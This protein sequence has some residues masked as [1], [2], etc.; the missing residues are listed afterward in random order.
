M[1]ATRLALPLLALGLA[2]SDEAV[3]TTGFID[4]YLDAYCGYIMRCCDA[5]ERS[6][7]TDTACRRQR[8]PYIQAL[9]ASTAED[10]KVTLVESKA[11]DC[12]KALN[13]SDCTRAT[14]A[15]GC[16]AGVTQGQQQSGDD[17]TYSPECASYYCIQDQKNVQGYCAGSSGGSC[18][19][20][21]R[22]CDQGSFCDDTKMQ[23]V[24]QVAEGQPCDRPEQCASGICAPQKYCV[25][26]PT[27]L[28]DGK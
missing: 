7:M 6:Y 24:P 19:G 3:T 5:V 15:A 26:A 2:C 28:C 10:A 8:E 22:A 11:R 13:D 21:D 1:S 25:A 9:L 18:S 27:P 4:D 23:C 12:I 17:C 14:A 20:D 16:L